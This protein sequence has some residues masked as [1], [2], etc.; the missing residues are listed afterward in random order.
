MKHTKGPWKILGSSTLNIQSDRTKVGER[1]RIA[2]LLATNAE[3]N[4][5]AALIAAAPE[6]LEALEEVAKYWVPTE[7]NYEGQAFFDAIG[8]VQDTINKAKGE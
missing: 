1:R 8:R 3:D 4:A 5:N 6:M 7:V 2:S